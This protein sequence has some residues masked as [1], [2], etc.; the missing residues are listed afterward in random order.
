MASSKKKQPTVKQT[1][2]PIAERSLETTALTIK[3]TLDDITPPIWRTFLV[4]ANQSLGFLHEILQALFL[5]E[6][7]H[8]HQFTS[9]KRCFQDL[10]GDAAEELFGENLEDTFDIKIGELLR[11]QNDVISYEYDFGDGWVIELR[12]EATTPLDEIPY[13]GLPVCVAGGR[14]A[15]PED[16]GGP[17]GY[18]ELVMAVQNPLSVEGQ[19]RLD[20]LGSPWD[21]E[22]FDVNFANAYLRLELESY[23]QAQV[24]PLMEMFHE[25]V[26][27]QVE[28][29]SPKF[30]KQTID[31]LI[32]AGSGED[33]ATALMAVALMKAGADP[34]TGKNLNEQL[35]KA[36]LAGL[37]EIAL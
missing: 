18:D 10:S 17:P 2:K 5:W 26:L 34:E 7:A 21:P 28:N 15:P 11:K 29:D 31:R 36:L 3:A 14:A 27:Q 25:L 23:C 8:L 19:D 12:L 35:Y 6:H 30:V 33:E 16:C 37:P 24:E 9:G 20:W 32:R 4:E 13:P 22:G 1:A